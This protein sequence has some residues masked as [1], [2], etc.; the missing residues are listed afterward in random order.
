VAPGSGADAMR[1]TV[2][3]DHAG[4]R[5]DKLLSRL[6]PDTSRATIQ[7]WISE[8]RVSVNGESCRAR[9]RVQAGA[10]IEVSPG[11][12]PVSDAKPDPGVAFAV[13]YEDAHLIVVDKPARLVVHPA[14]GHADGT[15]V[16]GLLARPGFV[17]PPGDPLDP[18]AALR[19]GIV[20]RLDKDTSG[21]LVVAKDSPTREGLKQQL[22]VHSVERVYLALTSG[23]PKA[24]TLRTLHGRHPRSRLR[25]TSQVTRGRPAVTHVRTVEELARGRAALVECRLETGRTHQIRVHLSERTKTPLLSDALYGKPAADPEVR[26]IADRLGRQA[27]HASVL[28]F[29]HPVTGEALRFVAELPEDFRAAL[30]SLRKIR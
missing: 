28:G 15:L 5:L 27:L 8:S 12:Q 26:A 13:L 2:L 22:S 19:P 18:Q 17:R 4:E 23:V 14:R 11:P 1:L 30:E 9:D 21:V 25:F 24:S 16:N 7:R 6:L 10:V 29:H 20:H 3:P